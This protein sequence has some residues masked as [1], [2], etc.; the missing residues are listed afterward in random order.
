MIMAGA[1][2]AQAG[3]PAVAATSLR[4]TAAGSG[5]AGVQLSWLNEEVRSNLPALLADVRRAGYEAVEPAG[6]SGISPGVWRRSLDA[7]GLRCR[8]IHLNF[9]NRGSDPGVAT[10]PA[11][12][13]ALC[14]AIGASR[15]VI[16]A[17]LTPDRFG[18][19]PEGSSARSWFE[20][21]VA[22]MSEADWQQ[23]AQALRTAA[24]RLGEDGLRVAY[25]NHAAEFSKVGNGTALDVL[26][27]STDP[28]LIDLELDVGWAA[29]AGADPV[30]LLEQHGRRIRQMHVRDTASVSAKFV[31]ARLGEGVVDWQAVFVAAR[32]VGVGE[33]YV[34][35]DRSPD[36][37]KI[38]VQDAAFLNS[39]LARGQRRGG[40][41]HRA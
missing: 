17:P 20:R 31:A 21:A 37:S 10:D 23:T 9:A 26:L 6:L 11:R 2:A 25:H 40:K 30:S 33:F 36:V 12:V 35:E 14:A 16:A 34:E 4:R 32:R 18:P 1:L 41:P 13:T 27:Y 38:L 3:I 19:P 15:V 28:S 7:V 8:S 24:K 39:L 22:G 29:A 5:L